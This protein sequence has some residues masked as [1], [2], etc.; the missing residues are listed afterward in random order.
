M[1]INDVVNTDGSLNIKRL[2]EYHDEIADVDAQLAGFAINVKTL[3]AVGDGVTDDTQA[4]LNAITNAKQI[5][6]PSGTYLISQP[7][8]I[9]NC[10]L[11]GSGFDTVLLYSGSGACVSMFG[12]GGVNLQ[13]S[14]ISKILVKSNRSAWNTSDMTTGILFGGSSGRAEDISVIGFEKG[15]EFKGVNAGSSYNQVF[16]RDI[17]DNLYGIYFDAVGSGWT[18]ENTVYGGRLTVT[19]PRQDP[20]TYG[21]YMTNDVANIHVPNNNKFIGLSVEG[22]EKGFHVEGLYNL[23]MG[24]RTEIDGIIAYEFKDS[25]S[26]TTPRWNNIIA[27]YGFVTFGSQ[28]KYFNNA[29]VEQTALPYNNISGRGSD[30]MVYG[31]LILDPSMVYDTS[32]KYDGT[33]IVF[34]KNNVEVYR[35][36]Q[37]YHNF[38]NKTTKNF[39]ATFSTTRPIAIKG[40]MLFDENI[41]KLIVHNG[42]NWVDA[43]GGVV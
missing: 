37:N 20:L 28:V 36:N 18:N 26:G 11:E 16:T 31:K 39:R 13:G 9:T 14:K 27:P 29:G 34:T 7:L 32:I 25:P 5:F 21:V 35:L 43:M 15:I 2:G 3:G 17:I 40:S 23:F 30:T 10:F 4:F 1:A 24:C 42:T 33:D 6:V 8:D 41:N 22:V 12:N 38:M 19:T